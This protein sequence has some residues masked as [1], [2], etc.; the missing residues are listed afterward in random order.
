[1]NLH[2]GYGHQQFW[3]EQQKEKIAMRKARNGF[4]FKMRKKNMKKKKRSKSGRASTWING[5]EIEMTYSVNSFPFLAAK[6]FKDELRGDTQIIE[7]KD[8]FLKD[9]VR[10]QL[11]QNLNEIRQSR[12]VIGHYQY[13][14]AVKKLFWIYR[15]SLRCNGLWWQ[16]DKTIK[17]LPMFVPEFAVINNILKDVGLK[18][19]NGLYFVD[20][21]RDKWA[22]EMSDLKLKE[23][24]AS[25]KAA[26]ISEG[27]I[28]YAPYIEE[29]RKKHLEYEKA[30]REGRL[31]IRVF[32][33]C[34]LPRYSVQTPTSS[35]D[36]SS[37]DDSSDDD[38]SDDDTAVTVTT[39]AN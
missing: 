23:D 29:T 9:R 24:L 10:T 14:V 32:C 22:S 4:F 6:P 25:G 38:S 12:K 20:S 5:I 19:R 36:D 28:A 35:D 2:L 26:R 27:I 17:F 8:F 15:D 3:R 30:K 31:I 37:D 16:P 11:K 39:N 21:D 34:C 7:T 13:V 1:M 33:P 18:K